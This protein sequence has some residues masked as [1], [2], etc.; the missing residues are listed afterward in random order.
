MLF[1]VKLH[2]KVFLLLL[3]GVHKYSIKKVTTLG[4]VQSQISPLVSNV[5]DL[6]SYIFREYFDVIFTM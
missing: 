4:H 6:N 2:L 5:P 1:E 3:G